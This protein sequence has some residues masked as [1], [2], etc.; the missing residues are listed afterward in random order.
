MSDKSEAPNFHLDLSQAIRAIL[1]IREADTST[2]RLRTA[3]DE[4]L[5][6]VFRTIAHLTDHI[7]SVRNL[8]EEIIACPLIDNGAASKALDKLRLAQSKA[9][10]IQ[11]AV[12]RLRGYGQMSRR[13]I[14]LIEQDLT[15][16]LRTLE[17]IR[18]Q[19]RQLNEEARLTQLLSTSYRRSF[20][21]EIDQGRKRASVT[22]PQAALI[23]RKA[24]SLPL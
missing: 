16:S 1:R 19:V 4:T 6:A 10:L 21:H 8:W 20:Y 24:V 7:G 5:P 22:T 11:K 18:I 15:Q 13:E 17:C 14:K 9:D 12:G 3:I 23:C 2:L